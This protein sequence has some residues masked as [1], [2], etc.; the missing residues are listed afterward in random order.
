M[1]TSRGAPAQA[2]KGLENGPPVMHV[3]IIK[4]RE[5]FAQ[6]SL[7]VKSPREVQES[8]ELDLSPRVLIFSDSAG[9]GGS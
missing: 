3:E 1:K 9:L 7:P 2:I 8:R 6:E 5:S 4:L